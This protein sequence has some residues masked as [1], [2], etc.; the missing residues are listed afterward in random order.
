MTE[1]CNEI[2]SKGTY[3]KKW[4]RLGYLLR[5][6]KI[7]AFEKLYFSDLHCNLNNKQQVVGQ[8]YLSASHA[9]EKRYWSYRK[10]DFVGLSLW[11][12]V[13]F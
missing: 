5:Q 10:H 7:F 13:P 8:T 4:L 6:T 11:N 1:P 2:I 12:K 9:I 3:D